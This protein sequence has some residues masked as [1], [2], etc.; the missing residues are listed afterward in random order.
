MTLTRDQVQQLTGDADRWLEPLNAALARWEISTPQRAAMFLAQCAHESGGFR[1]LVENLSYTAAQLLRTWPTRFTVEEAAAMALQPE[2]IGAR[3]YGGRM[4]NG[5]EGSG[6][7]YRFRGR[8]IIQLTGRDNYY[9]CGAALG[10]DLTADPDLLATPPLAAQS[11]G[12]FWEQHGC[13]QLA[14]AGDY[15]GVTRRINGG[16]NGWDDRVRWLAKVRGIIGATVAAQPAAPIEDRST[17]APAGAMT[18]E[19]K[20]MGAIALPLLAQLIPQVLGLFSGRAQATIA[21]KTGTDPKVA[22]DFLQAVIAQVGHAVGVPVVDN[23]TATQAVAALT[24]AAPDD[25]AAKAKALEAQALATLD[26]LLKAGDKMADWD[27]AMWAAQLAGRQASSNIAIAEKQAGLWDMTPVLVWGAT[28]LLGAVSVG[29]LAAILVQAMTGE[30]EINSALI[31]L[32][33]PIWTGA[34]VSGFVA[35]IAYRFD[36]TKESTEQSKA[37]A[38]VIRQRGAA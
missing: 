4:G 13:N 19:D 36:G 35:M 14:D 12:W 33:G 22:A 18:T 31:G 11:A 17:T 8:G 24:A 2:K 9:R 16:M 20:P 29:L 28:I 25:R 23:A 3:A 5:A 6:D 10:I 27:A 26:A 37:V 38:E 7:G 1:H 34:I 15:A 32:A 30:G 21:E